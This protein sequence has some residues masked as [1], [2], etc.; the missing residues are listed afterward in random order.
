ME[1]L[2]LEFRSSLRELREVLQSARFEGARQRAGEIVSAR[3]RE[4]R[5]SLENK[6]FRLISNSKWDYSTN[7]VNNRSTY[8]LNKEQLEV[9]NLGMGFCTGSDKSDIL[10]AVK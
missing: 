10:K 2:H 4:H 5:Q 1:T 8:P 6:L 3:G 7:K 9:L